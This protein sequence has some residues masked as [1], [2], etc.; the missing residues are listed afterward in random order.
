[1]T[2]ISDFRSPPVCNSLQFIV[3][4]VNRLTESSQR[5]HSYPLFREDAAEAQRSQGLHLEI[6]LLVSS[7]SG[8]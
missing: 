2:V 7:S 5:L 6:A 4:F 3:P 8:I 1:M